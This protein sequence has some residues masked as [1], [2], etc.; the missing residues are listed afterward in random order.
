VPAV[1][2]LN[3]EHEVTERTDLSVAKEAA[4]LIGDFGFD[5]LQNMDSRQA[6]HS[7][8]SGAVLFGVNQ[9]GRQAT[10]A[11]LR[12]IADGLEKPERT[13]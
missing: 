6:V 11:W 10:A 12:I 8:I 2:N 5:L 3:Q 7:M 4:T 9:F 13:N 1:C